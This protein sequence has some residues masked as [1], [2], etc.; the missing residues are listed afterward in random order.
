MGEINMSNKVKLN[1]GG[2]VVWGELISVQQAQEGWSQ[3]LL[4]DGSIVK[5]KVVVTDVF[6]VENEYDAE[7]N[8][9]YYVKS[10]NVVSVNA[11]EELRRKV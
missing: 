7:G 4:A 1:L 6:R 2:K 9:I 3:Y 10:T 8:P 5:M 11:S